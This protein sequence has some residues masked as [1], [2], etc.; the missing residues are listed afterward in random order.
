[1]GTLQWDENGADPIAQ[2]GAWGTTVN[3]SALGLDPLTIREALGEN[4]TPEALQA[5][6]AEVQAAL[7]HL[8]TEVRLGRFDGAPVRVRGRPVADWLDVP[9]LARLLRITEADLDDRALRVPD[10]HS[11]LLRLARRVERLVQ[12]HLLAL[13]LSHISFSK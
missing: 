4:P 5:L 1:M 3:A 8:S 13:V 10:I 11:L 12:C 6:L 7:A 2:F 9:S